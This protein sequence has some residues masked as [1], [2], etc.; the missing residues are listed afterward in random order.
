[1]SPENA[2]DEAIAELVTCSAVD[3]ALNISCVHPFIVYL[4]Q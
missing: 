3:G 2:I 1:V 4:Y